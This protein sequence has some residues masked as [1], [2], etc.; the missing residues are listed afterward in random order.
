MGAHAIA[1]LSDMMALAGFPHCN[2]LG[3]CEAILDTV[4]NTWQ[5]NALLNKQTIDAIKT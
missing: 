5:L 3:T 1:N 4:R 2:K